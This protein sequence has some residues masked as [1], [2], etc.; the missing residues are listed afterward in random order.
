M[1]KSQLFDI[2]MMNLVSV[3]RVKKAPLNAKKTRSGRPNCSIELKTSGKSI[4]TNVN[5]VE[6]VSDPEHPI[7]LPKGCSYSWSCVEPG[8]CLVFEIDCEFVGN[9]I[10]NFKISDNTFIKKIFT[11]IE[12]RSLTKSETKSLKNRR[13]LFAVLAF[14]L[15]SDN[16][17]YM[18]KATTKKLQPAIDY[19]AENYSVSGIT[20]EQLAALCDISVPYFRKLFSQRFNGSPISYLNSIRMHKAMEM[21]KGDY[22]SI[23]QVANDVGFTNIYHFS[24]EFK[25]Y[26]G[27]SPSEYASNDSNE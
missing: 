23:S 4:F 9:D 25:L 22:I 3:Y 14:L 2:E 26:T 27:V 11:N 18:P 7:F 17:V 10:I 12:L 6:V 13:D 15:D 20:N 19:I 8:E 1:D 24:K 21:L 5:G 16:K